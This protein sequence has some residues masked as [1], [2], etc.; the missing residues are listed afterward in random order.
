M[1]PATFGPIACINRKF[2]GSASAP[3]FC[4]T[5][6]AIGTADTPAE[7][8]SGFTFPPVT[9]HISLPNNTPAAVPN[10]NATSP[11]TTILIVSQFKNASALVVAPTEVPSRIT[12]IYINAFDAVSVSCLTTPHSLNKLP[13]ISMPTN[14]AVVGRISDTTIVMMIGNR[15][16]SSLDTGRSCSIL[17]FLSSSVVRSFMIGGWMIGTS[18]I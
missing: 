6:A 9:L 2:V 11:S 12:T 3:T 17:I 7:P 16:L 13:S 4:D 10:A 15:I 14:G 8:I 1:T 5:L 18:D